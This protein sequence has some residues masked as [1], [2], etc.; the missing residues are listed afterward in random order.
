MA[1]VKQA[2]MVSMILKGEPD[3]KAYQAGMQCSE[4]MAKKHASEYMAKHPEIKHKCLALIEKRED[5]TRDKALDVIS[6]GL[7]ASNPGRYGTVIEH[8]AQLESAKLLLRLYNELEPTDTKTQTL[9][10]T[11]INIV[12]S[13]PVDTLRSLIAEVKHMRLHKNDI[14]DGEVVRESPNIASESPSE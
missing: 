9:N 8:T 10:Q 13:I 4:E 12:N 6:R 2:K 3:Y 7:N 1:D 11:N 14:M 5:L